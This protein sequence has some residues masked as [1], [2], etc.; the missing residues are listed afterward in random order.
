MLSIDLFHNFTV[1]VL[2]II[3]SILD[4][5]KASFVLTEY[6]GTIYL[7]ARS[8]DEV[9]VQ[10]IAEKLGGGGHI[11]VAGAQFKDKTIESVR[12]M[13]MTVID[14]IVEEGDL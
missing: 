8:I 7:S 9:N 10:I 2:I 4:G 6:K 5:I 11:S 14:K 3:I 13:L 1:F 12:E